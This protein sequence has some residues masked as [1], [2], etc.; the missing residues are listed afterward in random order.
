VPLDPLTPEEF[1]VLAKDYM[2]SL[3]GRD[4]SREEFDAGLMQAARDAEYKKAMQRP[5]GERM[6]NVDLWKETMSRTNPLQIF[7]KEN[8]P[9]TLAAAG[10]AAAAAAAPVTG[11]MSLALPAIAAMGGGMTGKAITAGREGQGVEAIPDVIGRGALEGALSLV[12]AAGAG[13]LR[14]AGRGIREVGKLVAKQELLPSIDRL[15]ARAAM[16][17]KPLS[18]KADELMD[19]ALQTGYTRPEQ[20]TA[21]LQAAQ[22]ELTQRAAEATARGT[23]ADLP[24]RIPPAVEEYLLKEIEPKFAHREEARQAV[25]NE[26]ESFI[27][28]SAWTRQRPPERLAAWPPGQIRGAA[29][30]APAPVRSPFASVAPEREIRPDVTPS[31]LSESLRTGSFYGRQAGPGQQ[32]FLRLLE[33]QGRDALKA[34]VPEAAALQLTTGQMKDLAKI[35]DPAAIRAARAASGVADIGTLSTA[36]PF[37]LAA[38]SGQPLAA[39]AALPGLAW[40]MLPSHRLPAGMKMHR[41]IGPRFMRTGETIPP[42]MLAAA[43]RAMFEGSGAYEE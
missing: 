41:E 27:R 40:K 17:G 20:A 25:Q 1:D 13:A 43:L 30:A 32:E 16:E 34:A 2:L 19:V 7:S 10:G 38:V 3:G 12:P 21:A 6:T 42:E 14:G 39:L 22:E 18:T 23:R 24:E 15:A 29:E 26:W 8:L 35:L 9:S 28:G 36:G 4:I 33:K 11:G 31:E 5:F 37:G